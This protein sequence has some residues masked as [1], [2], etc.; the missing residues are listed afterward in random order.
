[1]PAQVKTLLITIALNSGLISSAC[2]SQN[3]GKWMIIIPAL[4]LMKCTFS[5]QNESSFQVQNTH[6]WQLSLTEATKTGF[7]TMMK[8]E[9]IVDF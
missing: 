5:L 1:V 2:Q 8:Q 3:K 4:L 7:Q 6:R 9:R